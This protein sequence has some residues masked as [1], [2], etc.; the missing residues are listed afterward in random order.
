MAMEALRAKL[1]ANTQFYPPDRMG[2]ERKSQP[3]EPEEV[4]HFGSVED[5]PVLTTFADRQRCAD[6]G[7]HRPTQAGIWG[8][9]EYGAY[10]IVMSGGYD[11][12]DDEGNKI[13]YTGT[14]PANVDQD[15]HYRDNLSLKISAETKNPVRVIRG[16]GHNGKRNNSPWAPAEGLRY[17]GLYVVTRAYIDKG[18]KGNK[19][20]RFEL[21]RLPGQLKIPKRY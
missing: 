19:I 1:M 7:M 15:P 11:D 12:D 2:Q 10:S 16:A 4:Q 17:D 21:V 13:I 6:S 3:P 9:S 18:K 20:C 8:S 14:G 5:I